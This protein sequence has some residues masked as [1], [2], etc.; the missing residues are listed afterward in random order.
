V[1]KGRNPVVRTNPP[2][3]PPPGVKNTPPPTVAARG[4]VRFVV[5]PWAVVECPQ[6]RFKDTTP[7]ADQQL[8]VGDYSFTFTNPDFPAQTRV[9][10]VEADCP[11]QVPVP[12]R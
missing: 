7:F 10:H 9:P 12:F 11:I 1:G 6:A 5:K 3:K 2:G 8:P 4:T